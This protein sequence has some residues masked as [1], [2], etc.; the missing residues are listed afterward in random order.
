M[1]VGDVVDQARRN[2]STKQVDRARI[3][4]V[5]PDRAKVAAVLPDLMQ[6]QIS[7]DSASSSDYLPCPASSG[8]DVNGPAPPTRGLQWMRRV[9]Q[10]TW[11]RNRPSSKKF[12]GGW[13]GTID[14]DQ[15]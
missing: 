14:G 3:K 5:M 11:K 4:A 12:V 8:V 9:F 7:N 6:I 1:T 10:H 15:R 2:Q 13:S